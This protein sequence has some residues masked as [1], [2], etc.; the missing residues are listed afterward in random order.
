MTFGEYLR[1]LRQHHDPPLT[2][3]QLAEKIGRSKM[4]ISSF[5]NGK[6]APPQEELLLQIIH[7]VCS[8]T[9]ECNQLRFLACFERKIVP[10]DLSDYFFSHPSICSVLRIAERQKLDD[11]FWERLKS[12]LEG[13]ENGSQNT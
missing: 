5:E 8:S 4:L 1:F 9:D 7:C 6:N 3:E 11:T 13:L 2:Q 12:Y 10:G